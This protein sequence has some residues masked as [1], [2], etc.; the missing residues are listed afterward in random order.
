[1]SPT[2]SCALFCGFLHPTPRPPTHRWLL[3]QYSDVPLQSQG[4]TDPVGKQQAGWLSSWLG[5]TVSSEAPVHHPVTCHSFQLPFGSRGLWLQTVTR[6]PVSYLISRIFSSPCWREPSPGCYC[7]LLAHSPA[8]ASAP[9][10]IPFL[11]HRN[12]LLF[13]NPCMH[14]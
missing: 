11:L 9:L 2:I 5:G 3:S 10:S 4:L 8:V 1:M 14:F 12:A 13:L 6:L 7:L